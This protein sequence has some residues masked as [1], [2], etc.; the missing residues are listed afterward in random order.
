MGAKK[1]TPRRPSRTAGRPGRPRPAKAA[2]KKR[3]DRTR[4]RRVTKRRKPAT[5]RIGREAVDLLERKIRRLRSA[6]ARLERRLT[7]AVQEIGTL[8]QFELRARTLEG[9]L[10]KREEDLAAVRRELESLIGARSTTAA[11][12]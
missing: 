4:A 11:R 1:K 2:A 6:R 5:P 3:H 10:R 9:H 7:E 8:R 12:L